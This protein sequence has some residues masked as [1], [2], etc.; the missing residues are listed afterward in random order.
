MHL[1]DWTV[2]RFILVGG[3]NTLFGLIVIFTCKWTFGL[4]DV[5]SNLMGY[6]AG[7]TLSFVLNKQWTFRYNGILFTALMRFVFV[8]LVAYLVNLATVL[9]LIKIGVDS[10]LAQL[11][12]VVPYT[13]FGFL[14]SR[15]FVFG[16]PRRVSTS[17][18]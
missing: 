13:I 9:V 8:L 1:T 12:G 7:I 16:H 3:I 17:S 15:F 10:Y 6:S 2:V 4:H 18:S 5:L 11:M 14:G